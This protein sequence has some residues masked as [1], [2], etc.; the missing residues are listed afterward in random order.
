M[1]L[2]FSQ[3]RKEAPKEIQGIS[4][5]LLAEGAAIGSY[6]LASNIAWAGYVGLGCVILGTLLEKLTAIS[7]NK[8]NVNLVKE[9]NLITLTQQS[10]EIDPKDPPP[11]Q[12]Q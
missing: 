8:N 1:K 11:G 3:W 6:G 9:P 7:E 5:L 2:G 4:G 12:P 10:S